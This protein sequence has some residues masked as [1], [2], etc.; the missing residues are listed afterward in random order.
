MTASS[1]RRHE[2]RLNA[3]TRRCWKQARRS[4]SFRISTRIRGPR[5]S[6]RP[7]RPA[8]RKGCT[9]ATVRSCCTCLPRWSNTAWRRARAGFIA[10]TSLHADDADVPCPCLGLPLFL[11]HGRHEAG[12][13]RA[14]GPDVLLRLIAQERVTFTHCV[15]TILQMLLGAPGSKDVD[16][17]G[18]KMVVGGSALP[19]A[20]ARAALA[21]GIDVFTG[22]GQSESCPML[23][24]VHL[25]AKELSEDPER[26]VEVRTF[27]GP[28]AP[29]VDLRI[30]DADMAEV[31]RD[32]K[33][34]GEIVTR[35]PWLTMGYLNNAAASEQLWA[36]GY[37]HTGDVATWD[38]DGCI[39]IVDRLKDIIKSGGEW[40]SSIQLEDIILEKKGVLKAAVIAVR[41]DK[42]GERP[43]ALAT[44]DPQFA[45]GVPEAQEGDWRPYEVLR[46]QGRHFEDGDSGSD[47]DR[48]Q[49]AA[50][51]GGQSRHESAPRH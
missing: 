3:N 39:H 21:R 13:S 2:F 24:G 45:G 9:S 48:R 44:V 28:P 4:F 8:I 46:G 22:Y 12:L 27:A 31:P 35:A 49:L 43:M 15:P 47:H 17:S 34:E 25:G 23:S 38:A 16:L 29:L 10:R 19:R 40:V 5:L 26:Q 32:G 33:S 14:F 37:L 36:G 50:D 6:T 18:L 7:A 1:G 41:D 11:D 42:W 20:L 51:L 30:V